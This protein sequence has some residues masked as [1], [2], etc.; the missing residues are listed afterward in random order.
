VGGDDIALHSEPSTAGVVVIPLGS[1]IAFIDETAVT[2]ALPHYTGGIRGERD[3]YPVPDEA[4]TL[5]P[6]HGV[7][8]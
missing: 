4:Y 8:L 5:L 7:V 2:M 6:E 1:S 3:R